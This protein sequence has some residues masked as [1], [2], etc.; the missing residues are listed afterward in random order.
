MDHAFDQPIAAV[1]MAGGSVRDDLT[2]DVSQQQLEWSTL[3]ELQL[4]ARK[5]QGNDDR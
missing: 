5:H 2:G 1:A 3:E 4:H